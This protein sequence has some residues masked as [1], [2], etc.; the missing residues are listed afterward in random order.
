MGGLWLSLFVLVLVVG[1]LA[2]AVYIAWRKT[3]AVQTISYY[4][5]FKNNLRYAM[6]RL[7]GWVF[8]GTLLLAGLLIIRPEQ[9][10]VAYYKY[11]LVIGAAYAGYW[12]DRCAFPYARP[13]SYLKDFWQR[14]TKE[15]L[16]QADYEVV[17]EYRLIFALVMLRRALVM[18]A[19]ILGVTLGL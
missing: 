14:G 10:M 3:P 5:A 13:D 8:F 7:F 12:L 16:N 6:P 1:L 15:P 9:A 18:T 11:A 4:V 19:V 17:D 2:T